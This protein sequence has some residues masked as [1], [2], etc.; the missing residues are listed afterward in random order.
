MPSKYQPT[1]A[2]EA[3]ATQLWLASPTAKATDLANGWPRLYRLTKEYYYTLARMALATERL[4]HLAG[5]PPLE[6]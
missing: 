6:L 1:P 2:V 4:R 3:K 5:L